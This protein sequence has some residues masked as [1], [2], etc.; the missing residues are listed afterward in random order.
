MKATAA[1]RVRDVLSG[2]FALMV[3]ATGGC[4]DTRHATDFVPATPPA[5]SLRV[6]V[7]PL[8]N[9]TN[10]PNAGRIVAEL[11]ATELYARGLFELM[12]GTALRRALTRRNIDLAALGESVVAGEVAATLGVDALLVG[13]VSEY[14]YQHGLHEEP[15]VGINLRLVGSGGEVVWAASHSTTG[16]GYIARDSVNASAQ[17]LVSEMIDTLEAG[18]P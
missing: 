1:G 3:L 11:A 2:L 18:M 6:A 16:R 5:R 10:F 7:V 15:V 12:E 4:T 13:S 9:L 17:R 8:E 14:G